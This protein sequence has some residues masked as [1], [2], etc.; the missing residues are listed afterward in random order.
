M[1]SD[2]C[3]RV[4]ALAATCVVLGVPAGCQRADGAGVAVP[5]VH[6]VLLLEQVADGRNRAQ[7]NYRETVAVC[8]AAGAAVSPLDAE[9]VARLDT[10]RVELWSDGTRRLSRE[11]TWSWTSPGGPDGL[12]LFEFVENVAERYMDATVSGWSGDDAD[13]GWHEAP[14]HPGDF[15]AVAVDAVEDDQIAQAS[16]WTPQGTGG[17]R[18]Q[19]CKRWRSAREEA[20]MW[21]GGLQGGFSAAPPGYTDCFATSFERFEAAIPLQVEPLD[22]N[23]CRI[24]LQSMQVGTGA[25]PATDVVPVT[26]KR[27]G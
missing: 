10:G 18:G 12:C 13:P 23:G 25:L 16:G 4:F 24:R 14:I 5:A 17:E 8:E 11:T 20:C 15:A 21:S 2:R 1:R 7:D 19:A 22:G 27:A 26:R 3:H 9:Q 6:A